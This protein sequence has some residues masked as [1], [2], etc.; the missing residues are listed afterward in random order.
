M[1]FK[2]IATITM[3]ALLAIS[4]SMPASAVTKNWRVYHA[5]GAPTTSGIFDSGQL[6]PKGG[7]V[8]EVKMTGYENLS[9]TT[10]YAYRQGHKDARK[11]ITAKEKICFCEE[12]ICNPDECPYAKGHFDR[13]NDAV[14]EL[15]STKDECT[16][17]IIEEQARKYHV[18]PF[19]MS[20]DVSEWMDAIICDYN[21]VFD[22]DAHLKRFFSEAGT[23]EY[24]FL[25]DEAHNLVERGR[26]MY[27]ATLYKEDFLSMKKLFQSDA[28][29]LAKRLD[30]CNKQ[31]LA[32]KRECETYQVIDNV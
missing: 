22:P 28:P 20:L 21:Y 4:S 17:E 32:L 24:L 27:S 25:I 30:E 5:Q 19:E 13:V 2:K 11:Y 10:L 26:E 29:K 3:A 1:N 9:K 8:C 18:C 23:G 16:R 14:F 15:I 31:L 7:S 6:M 12:T